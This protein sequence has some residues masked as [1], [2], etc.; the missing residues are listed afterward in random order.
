[1]EV[2]DTS[3]ILAGGKEGAEELQRQFFAHE[4]AGLESTLPGNSRSVLDKTDRNS[5]AHRALQAVFRSIGGDWRDGGAW[6]WPRE[7]S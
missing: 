4:L 6:A 7:G 1:M 5:D 2:K 3:L